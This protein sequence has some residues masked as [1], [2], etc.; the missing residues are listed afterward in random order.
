M[1]RVPVVL[2]L[3]TSTG[4]IEYTLGYIDLN[5]I[6]TI[7][8]LFNIVYNLLD[9]SD[10]YN[11]YI[12]IIDFNSTIVLK[13]FSTNLEFNM[14]KN[15]FI[16]DNNNYIYVRTI[17]NFLESNPRYANKDFLRKWFNSD[18][19]I[20]DPKLYQNVNYGIGL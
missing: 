7:Q 15:A 2:N 18:D 12:T 6:N 5:N 14:F 20:R 3:F 13:S 8:E 9:L 16:E 1:N 11:G 10:L 17:F 19:K 4:D